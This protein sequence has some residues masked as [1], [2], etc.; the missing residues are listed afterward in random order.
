MAKY[1]FT[2]K[3]DDITVEFTTTDR[4]IVERQFQLWVSS[5]SEYADK[6]TPKSFEEKKNSKLAETIVQKP[7]KS[8]E[9]NVSPIQHASEAPVKAAPPIVEKQPESV[10][11]QP[12]IKPSKVEMVENILASEEASEVFD[13]ASSLLKTINSIQKSEQVAE[14]VGEPTVVEAP[15]HVDFDKVLE[16][17]IENPT[18]EPVKTKDELFLGL[19]ASKNTTDKFHYLIITAHYLLGVENMDR[20]SLKQINAKLMQNLSEIVDHSVLQSA[21]DQQFVE[22]VPDLTGMAEISEYRLTE[23]G[24]E[25]FSNI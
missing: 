15:A 10:V 17:S 21:I 4:Y 8:Q 1:T 22:V 3:K 9:P 11:I 19:I 20:F 5:A 13:K 25:F 7:K 12:E 6:M 18:F 24:E 16:K 23:K 14:V 2:F